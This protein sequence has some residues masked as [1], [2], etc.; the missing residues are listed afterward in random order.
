MTS[1]VA[2]VGAGPAGLFCAIQCAMHGLKPLILEKNES[3]G[4][5]L[6]LSGS[7]KCNITHSGNIKDFLYHYGEQGRFV[8]PALFNFSNREMLEFFESRNLK[9]VD[10]HEGKVFP[11]T[12][13][14]KDVLRVLLKECEHKAIQIEY[15]DSVKQ[16]TKTTNGF[17]IT[18]AAKS[19]FAEAVV[20]STGGKSYPKTGSSGDGYAIAKNLGHTITELRPALTSVIIKDFKYLSCAGI[21]IK[22]A[23]VCLYRNNK[24]INENKGDILFTHKGLSGPGILDISR[25]IQTGDS[26]KIALVKYTDKEKFEEKLISAINRNGRREFK[27]LLQEFQVPERLVDKI[28]ELSNISSNIKASILDKKT[29]KLIV[30]ELMEFPACV[31]S[32]GDFNEAMVTKGGILFDEINKNTMESRIVPNLY[33]TGE[34]CDVD[35]D[36]GGYNLQFAF[37]S[38][39]LAGKSIVQKFGENKR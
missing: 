35:G 34:I 30:D 23:L 27:N 14:G 15:S 4:K 13:N 36:T 5:K 3:S 31:E 21:S 25:F 32:L 17:E 9:L 20:I 26:L 7:G 22:N 38:G 16:I 18:T 29:R 12:Q 10:L 24:K 19:H 39:M 11:E 28:F 2:I 1:K 33:F 6:I 37:S 8:K